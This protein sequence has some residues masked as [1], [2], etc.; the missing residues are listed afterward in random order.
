[1]ASRY[2]QA[3]HFDY[4]FHPI[5]VV[6]DTKDIYVPCGRCDGCLLHKAQVWSMRVGCE[7][8]ATPHSIF[9][10]L[11]YSNKYLPVMIQ[12]KCI[13]D[14]NFGKVTSVRWKVNNPY[15][16]RFD[17]VKD[18]PRK[19]DFDF[20]TALYEPVPITHFVDDACCPSDLLGFDIQHFMAYS[21]KRDV[22]LWLKMLNKDLRQTFNYG[23]ESKINAFRYFIISEYGE[24]LF[25]PHIHGIIFPRCYDEA[26]YLLQHSLFKNWQM[27]D[28][29]LFDRYV[30]FCDS[31][32]KGYIT[33]YLTCFSSLPKI[34]KDS[35]EIQP[36][37]LSSKAPAIGFILQDKEKIFEDVSHGVIEYVTPIKRLGVN[38][39]H[40]YPSDFMSTIFPKCYRYSQLDFSR[41]LVVYGCI[42]EAYRRRDTW[43][44]YS[45]SFSDLLVGFRE[46]LNPL[47]YN[48]AYRC[49]RTI[50]EWHFKGLGMMSVFHYCY[51]VDMYY[52]KSAMTSLKKWYQ[53]QQEHSDNGLLILSTYSS[54]IWFLRDSNP[55]LFA[56]LLESLHLDVDYFYNLDGREIQRQL[57]ETRSVFH[58]QYEGDV[59]DITEDMVKKSKFSEKTGSSPVNQYV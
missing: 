37:R 35:E 34:Y 46:N 59:Y 20:I 55:I 11:T 29:D 17:G 56:T 31:G 58:K 16:I 8:E 44:K 4:C 14:P 1:M 33:Q 36:F 47:D 40:L 24:T 32:V 49:F 27:C 48:A 12:D 10:T 41:V 15:N 28:K 51:L 30:H 9:F 6:D 5:H 23:T 43:R 22:Q 42:F 18:K 45:L 2:S 50:Q 57:K 13:Y 7:I 19:E 3:P 52:Y 38:P 53:F 26:Q 54:S 25:R 21:S 39:V